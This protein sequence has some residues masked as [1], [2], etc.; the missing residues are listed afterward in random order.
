[1]PILRIIAYMVYA[2]KHR[3]SVGRRTRMASD[4]VGW[5]YATPLVANSSPPE[6][7]RCSPGRSH[8]AWLVLPAVT[9]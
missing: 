8:P 3:I 9:V 5:H 2:Y 7:G 6:T 1:V 4:G